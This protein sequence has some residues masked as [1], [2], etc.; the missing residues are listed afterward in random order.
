MNMTLSARNTCFKIG[1]SVSGLSLAIIIAA[2]FVILPAYPKALEESVSRAAGIF[3]FFV[4]NRLEASP[5]VPFATVAGAVLFSLIGIILISY[6]FEKTQCQEILFVGLFVLSFAFESLRIMIPLKEVLEFPILYAANGTRVLIFGRYFGLF[7]L[8]AAS[9][10]S[11]GLQV[12]KQ[13]NIIFFC[14]IGS[15]VI[16]LGIPVDG[17]SWDTTL[18]MLSDYSEAFAMI[19]WGILGITATS[20][21]ISAYTRGSKEY[22]YIGLGVLITYLGRD[23]LL[24]SDT[25]ISPVPGLI[26]L[27]LGTWF[28]CIKLHKIYLWF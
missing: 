9:L 17:L 19:Q 21:F 5:Y 2:A 4:T 8:F 20:F 15:M 7:S 11:A 23:I 26:F 18:S 12:Q 13:Q 27:S 3:Q 24:N 10:Y 22:V 16:A 28:L 1:I 6:F 25:W 14:V